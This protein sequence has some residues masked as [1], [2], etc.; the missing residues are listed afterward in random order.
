[1]EC[2][3]GRANTTP[4]VGDEAG[5]DGGARGPHPGAHLVGQLVENLEVLARL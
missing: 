5:V 3:S 2:E 1:M 4:T